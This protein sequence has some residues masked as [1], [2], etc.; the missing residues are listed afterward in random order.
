MEKL[1]KETMNLES[2]NIEKIK[3]SFPSVVSEGKVDFDKLRLLLGDDVDD[4][5][6]KFQFTWHGK[7]NAIKHAQ[8]PSTGTLI[9]DK[10]SS[11]HFDST[12]NLYIEGDNLEVLKQ[13]QKTYFGKI[14]MI[15][16]DP[17]YNTGNDF[18][19]KDDFKNS[20]QNYK[21]QTSQT[22]R[23]N[24]E[25]SGRYHT[26]W[27]NMMYAR[28]LVS[29]NLLK[30]DGVF[31]VSISDN[32]IANL[33]KVC[34][35]IFGEKNHVGTIIWNSTKSVTNT[36]IISVSHTYNLVYFKNIDYFIDNRNEFRLPEDGMGFSNP[37]DDPRGPWKADP[38]QVGGWRPNQQYEI[39]N[40]NT[41]QTYRPNVGSSWKNDYDKYQELLKDGRIVFG[42]YGES[43][44]QRKR[45]L[46]EAR[47]RGKVAQTWWDDVDTTTNG[48]QLLKRLFDGRMLFDNPKP[49]E[50]IK[51]FITLASS[52]LND[53]ILDFFSGSATT[54]HA[55]MKLN[56]DDGGNRQFI[57]VQLPEVT[58]PESEAAKA[59]YFNIC[60]IGKERIRRAGEQVKAELEAAVKKGES[61]VDPTSLD[62]GFK[63]FKLDSTNIKPWDSSSQF[64]EESLFTQEEVIKEDRTTSDVLYEV[65]L[66]YGV[67]DQ[68]VEELQINGKTMYGVG[69][70]YLL[71]SLADE[72]T[73]EDITEIG[74]LKPHSV[75]FKESGFK[76]DNAKMNATYTLERLGV[77]DI[78]SL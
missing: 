10:A 19:Y 50:L 4:S 14:K 42:V 1:N 46:Y 78:K 18:V 55:V 34:D 56:A 49:H 43:G 60:E 63:V 39:I 38:F 28:I 44:P 70:N 25:T 9:P 58:D 67:F 61:E 23:S 7:S 32:E 41:H 75:I 27:L 35:E 73:M 16:I 62:I 11:K 57:M 30:N 51:R 24:P 47:E 15:Y 71:V 22:S 53:I 36:A 6:E 72:I 37:D 66:K 45:F 20:I 2:I 29:K 31:I 69:K 12:G 52:S 65:L 76:D 77:E 5:N 3:E 8:T 54:A 59:G 48:T 33:K 68:P 64:T 13:L 74:K 17:P 26:D 21:E 40:P